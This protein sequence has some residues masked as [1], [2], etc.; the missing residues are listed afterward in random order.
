MHCN[1]IE[2]FDN[3]L[4]KV[5]NDKNN[6]SGVNEEIL[7]SSNGRILKE[8]D[9]AGQVLQEATYEQLSVLSCILADL[10]RP[11]LRKH[12]VSVCKCK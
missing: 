11:L 8:L 6:I 5:T 4:I 1:F 9:A 2:A 7:K 12:L 10:L 3:E